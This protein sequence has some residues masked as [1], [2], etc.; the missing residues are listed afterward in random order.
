MKEAFF[1]NDD[2]DDT[3]YIT[4]SLSVSILCTHPMFGPDSGKYGWYNL[5]LVYDDSMVLLETS[6]S[7]HDDYDSKWWLGLFEK[8]GCRLVKMT[9]SDHDK[10][11]AATQ[12]ITHL[13]G[14][15]LGGI[16]PKLHTTNIDTLGFRSLIKL[17]NNTI[18]DR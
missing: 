3:S 12:F 8:C 11:A 16:T 13:T 10:I 17:M 15:V 18:N 7:D 4:T 2:D 9:S 1:Q 14:R 6:L 5:P